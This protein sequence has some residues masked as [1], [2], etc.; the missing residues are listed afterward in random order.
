MLRLKNNYLL[1]DSVRFWVCSVEEAFTVVIKSRA[2]FRGTT[3]SGCSF[4]HQEIE[5]G[6]VRS[7]TRICILWWCKQRNS[8]LVD[9][10]GLRA[11]ERKLTILSHKQ[12]EK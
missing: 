8:S 5:D 11:T 2:D 4:H 3:F 1:F 9:A 7:F 6:T 12:V 10:S